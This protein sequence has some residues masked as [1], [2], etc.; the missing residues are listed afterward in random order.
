M[1]KMQLAHRNLEEDRIRKDGG[2]VPALIL[3]SVVSTLSI[4]FI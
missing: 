4:S 2:E 1:F 3:P